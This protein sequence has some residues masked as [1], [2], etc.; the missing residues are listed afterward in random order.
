MF[1][2]RNAMK[3][4]VAWKNK[5]GRKP[6]L[7]YGARQVGKTY[8]VK[9]FGN[10]YFKDVIYVNFE[11]NSIVSKIIDEDITPEYIIK[12]LEII[13][14]KKID[15]DDTLI[16]FDEIQ[17][18]TRALTS[19]KYFCE[20]APEYYV[21]GAGSLLGVHINEK[22]YSFPVGKVD[23]MTVYPMSFD[24]FLKSTDN[25][26]LIDKIRECYKDN[27]SMPDVLH[28][29]AL[30]LYYDYL[31]IG[32]M[33]E[34][35]SEYIDSN[36]TISAIEYQKNIIE[37]YKNDITKYCKD[38]G[39]ANKI[40]A[41]FDSIP[42]QLAK[43]NKKFQ[44]KL[45]Q[46]GGSSTIFGNSINWLV[47]A[48]I[49]NKCTKTKIGVPLKMYEEIE[50]FKL[51]L[52]DVGLLTNLTEFP[53]YLI[54]NRNAVNET[55]IGMLTEN[56]VA[57][58]LKY[59]ENNLNYYK[60]EYDTEVDFILQSRNGLIIPLEV[61]VGTHIK[62]RSLSNYVKE[63]NPKYAIRLSMRNF[64]FENNIKSVPLYA[65]FCINQDSLDI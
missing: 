27:L 52:N 11:K 45:I 25:D 63:Y 36:S 59:N 38:T 50:S 23:I 7:L 39:E 16:F 10:K 44:Y 24:E 61:K 30:D 1:M 56:Y 53:L 37:S 15:K 8:L 12:N 33:P 31:M 43:D 64:G 62:S 65:V 26:M 13:F 46:K 35:V 4:L 28:N 19:L 40:I 48:G 41:T 34:V 49:V 5:K 51:Y 6:L 32:G 29:K 42:I 22:D 58:S 20:D 60:N 55:M 18:N 17:R 47:N 54:K 3:E 9:E 21:I 57:S 2:E 14:N